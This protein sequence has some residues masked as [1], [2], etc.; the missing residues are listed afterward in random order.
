MWDTA[1]AWLD[2]LCVGLHP[3]SG[4]WTGATKA[5][6]MSLTT[7]PP[8]WPLDFFRKEHRI[9][10]QTD[11]VSKREL[12]VE[13][14]RDVMIS[15][16]ERWAGTEKT[17]GGEV[18]PQEL[19]KRRG[20]QNYGDGPFYTEEP[21]EQAGGRSQWSRAPSSGRPDPYSLLRAGSG[22]AG[23]EVEQGQDSSSIQ[24][25]GP[26]WSRLVWGASYGEGSVGLGGHRAAVVAL[27]FPRWPGQQ[28]HTAS[29]QGLLEAAVL[30]GR[31]GRE[32]APRESLP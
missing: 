11:L 23:V 26:P 24:D 25:A 31:L 2:E 15:G 19:R 1:T 6:Q 9:R 17:A 14:G 21:S 8:G 22:F 10:S 16:K 18:G 32:K 29:L 5:E 27:T 28:P 4:L 13:T 12:G 7:M 3:E 30:R 20:T